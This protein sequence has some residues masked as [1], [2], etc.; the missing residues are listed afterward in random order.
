MRRFTI[1]T[2]LFL[3]MMP[4]RTEAKEQEVYVAIGDSLAAGQTPYSQIDAGYTDF[5][6]LQLQRNGKLAHFTKELSFPGYRV[7]NVLESVQS[8]KADMLLKDATLITVSAGANNLLPLISY[9]ANAGTLAFSQ[10]SANFA[11]NEVR[12]QMRQLL[13][14]LREK[15]P[16]AEIYVM[17]YYFPYVSVHEEQAEG[18]ITSLNMLNRILQQETEQAN[19]HFVDVYDAFNE[20]AQSYLPNLSDIHPIQQGY[21]LMANQMLEQYSGNSSFEMRKE[22][23]PQPDPLTFEEILQLR[24][25]VVEDK[26]SAPK[27]Y[28]ASPHMP[29]KPQPLPI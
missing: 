18:A 3:F 17:G 25:D 12:I 14:L 9:N 26:V 22:A 7:E 5:I 28:V 6:A 27:L 4:F 1:L 13:E 21:R 8:E 24:N 15:A 19:A 20:R 23:M 16:A 2:A 29:N 10:L 11:L